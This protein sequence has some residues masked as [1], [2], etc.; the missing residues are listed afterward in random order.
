MINL[1]AWLDSF[2]PGGN[3]TWDLHGASDIN[4]AGMITGWGVASGSSETV[5]FILDAST[6]VPEPSSAVLM[7][8]ASAAITLRRR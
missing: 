2:T 7:I 6:L 1:Q 5:G 3:T 8:L 4:D